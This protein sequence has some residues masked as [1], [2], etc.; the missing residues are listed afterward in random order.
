MVLAVWA[1]QKGKLRHEFALCVIIA[2]VVALVLAKLAGNLYYHPRPFMTSAVQPLVSHASDNG[3]PSD[4]TI[5]AT[6]LAMT[7][8]FYRLRLGIIVFVL[9]AL[10]GI[11][12]VAARVHSPVDILG[13]AALGLIAG[14]AGYWLAK[15]LLAK[16][17][18][19]PAV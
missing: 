17:T 16:H 14:G 7:V 11:G 15:R 10:I 5:V 18:K 12:R 8:Y 3:F 4:H 19:P 13:G 9:A 2:A 1:K 6:A